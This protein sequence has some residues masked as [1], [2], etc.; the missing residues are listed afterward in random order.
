MTSNLIAGLD[1]G[2]TK[3][4]AVI[5]EFL[6]KSH[7]PEL[8]VLGVASVETAGIRDD[9]ISDM[10]QATACIRQVVQ[11]AE[12]M[13]DASIDRLYVGVSGGHVSTG[14]SLGVVPIYTSEIIPGDVERVHEVARA[15]ALPP[16]R[17]ILHAIPQEYMVDHQGGI[18][19]PIGMSGVRLETDVLIVTGCSTAVGNITKAVEKAGYRVQGRILESLAAARAVLAEDEKNLGVAVLDLGGSATGL[20][21]YCGGKIRDLQVLPVGGCTVTGDLIRGL[22]V[23]FADAKLI[24]ELHG[25][26]SGRIVDGGQ[27]IELAGRNGNA[28]SVTRRFVADL[29]WERLEQI[30]TWVYRRL[31]DLQEEVVLAAG[32]VITGGGASI[33]GI[34]EM[35]QHSFGMPA[36]V[37][38]PGEGLTGLSAEISRPDRAV[39]AGLALYGGDHFMDTGLG[40]STRTSGVVTRLGAWLKEFF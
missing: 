38:L 8:R 37:G 22:S 4:R 9:T 26:A 23:S 18:Y 21:I 24:K 11:E 16:D 2:S 19:D 28:R 7:R 29:M 31:N 35:A 5:G 34:A 27:T 12:T 36:R 30:F 6:T 14:P 13:A 39:A 33:P 20:S 10:E 1:I 3:T 25:A 15:V 40:A 32:V 17:E